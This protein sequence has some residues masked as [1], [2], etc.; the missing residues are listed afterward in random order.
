MCIGV[1]VLAD[2]AD[3]ISNGLK[4]VFAPEHENDRA[5]CWFPMRKAVENLYLTIINDNSLK[6]QHLADI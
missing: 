4:K 1:C 5:M 6:N 3:A 2:A